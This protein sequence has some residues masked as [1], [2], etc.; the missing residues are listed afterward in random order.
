M[1]KIGADIALAT[2]L[3]QLGKL[4][5][6]NLNF[7]RSKFRFFMTIFGHACRPLLRWL[8][9]CSGATSA[10]H[11]LRFIRKQFKLPVYKQNHS[12]KYVLA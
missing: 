11:S 1:S 9:Y 2:Q 5:G 4:Q 8:Y 10:Y 12:R 6:S 7:D 3:F